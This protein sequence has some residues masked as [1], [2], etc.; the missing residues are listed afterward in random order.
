MGSIAFTFV[1]FGLS[2]YVISA[3][4][5]FSQ[6]SRTLDT[7]Q[8]GPADQSMKG[9]TFF[10]DNPMF[11][12]SFSYLNP[13]NRLPG[14]QSMIPHFIPHHMKIAH[15]LMNR[16]QQTD[17]NSRGIL[18]DIPELP[19]KEGIFVG[20]NPT[21][22]M[23]NDTSNIPVVSFRNAF[24]RN[25]ANQ[26]NQ[27]LG[28]GQPFFSQNNTA[29]TSSI[30]GL[31]SIQSD[32]SATNGEI[33]ASSNTIDINN[34][35]PSMQLVGSF[36]DNRG[37]P[38]M[39][40]VAEFVDISDAVAMMPIGQF[41]DQSNQDS[42]RNDVNS[43]PK[44]FAKSV[45]NKDAIDIFWSPSN[46]SRTANDVSDKPHRLD[47]IVFPTMRP[48]VSDA[49]L[50]PVDRPSINSGEVFS[51]T[52]DIL[53][54]NINEQLSSSKTNTGGIPVSPEVTGAI[55]FNLL[56]GQQVNEV[57]GATAINA[58]TTN[59]LKQTVSSNIISVPARSS[60]T[61]LIQDVNI[62]QI[63]SPKQPAPVIDDSRVGP[64]NM[65]NAMNADGSFSSVLK[66]V[67]IQK[68]SGGQG[69]EFGINAIP[70]VG[71]ETNK[72]L[73][74][75]IFNTDA[76][77]GKRNINGFGDSTLVTNGNRQTD[78]LNRINEDTN[79]RNGQFMT[80]NQPFSGRFE[81]NVPNDQQLNT[82]MI[83][84]SSLNGQN[85]QGNQ[86]RN[87]LTDR[88]QS[89]NKIAV[90]IDGTVIPSVQNNMQPVNDNF[91]SRIW[92][93]RVR[94]TTLNGNTDMPNGNGEQNMQ[95]NVNPLKSNM[96]AVIGNQQIA[97]NQDNGRV[98]TGV[99]DQ[100]SQSLGTNGQA[101]EENTRN[102]RLSMPNSPQPI[103]G[104]NMISGPNTFNNQFVGQTG[105]ITQPV[106]N[107]NMV[108]RVQ[109]GRPANIIG[110]S[111]PGEEG[112]H[113]GS[114]G[115]FP[116][117]NQVIVLN[118]QSTQ[119]IRTDTIGTVGENGQTF[120][121]NERQILGMT[122]SINNNIGTTSQ[123]DPAMT[124]NIRGVSG[125]SV[126]IGPARPL[127]GPNNA[128][129][130]WVSQS[131]MSNGITRALGQGNN[132]NQVPV[133][134]LNGNVVSNAQ[135]PQNVNNERQF[136]NMNKNGISTGSAQS[137]VPNGN[138][139]NNFLLANTGQSQLPQPM[140]N[141]QMMNTANVPMSPN[142]QNANPAI[143]SQGT[144]FNQPTNPQM[145]DNQMM[146][147]Q[148]MTNQ[149][150]NSIQ[151]INMQGM[152]LNQ[153][154]NNPGFNGMNSQV[155]GPQGNA[156]FNQMNNLGVNGMN[157]PGLN[158]MNNPGLNGM[159]SQVTGGMNSP[160]LNGMNS[161]PL[162]GM[163]SPSLNGMI[164]PQLNGMNSPQLNGM[165][166]P[167]LNGMNSHAGVQGNAMLN[168]MN[169]QGVNGMNSLN[170]NGMN[171]PGVNGMNNPSVNGM[172]NP[173]VNGI[174]PQVIGLQGNAMLNQMNS[175]S[176]N[177]V[178]SQGAN[179][180]NNPGTNE[181]NSK[182]TGPQGN[183]MFNQMNSRGVNGMNSPGVNVMNN[184]GENGMNSQVTGTQGNTMFNQINSRG[185]S[186]MNS[187]GV[188][189]MNSP[190][191]NGM[192]SQVTG[193]QGTAIFNQMN[194]QGIMQLPN[195]PGAQMNNMGM[196]QPS[197]GQGQ[198]S[199]Q[200]NNP[201][202]M[203]GNFQ[204]PMNGIPHSPNDPFTINSIGGFQGSNN[205]NLIPQQN[206]NNRIRN[207]DGSFGPP[208]QQ[209]N[210][211]NNMGQSMPMPFNG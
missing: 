150:M 136:Q 16:H 179:G 76:N 34:Q 28:N 27:V 151:P 173:V 26:D 146:N 123:D 93:I 190:G 46:R 42:K 152:N 96:G 104:N 80:E 157:S 35:N 121:L 47:D 197:N 208:M 86:F 187:P 161:P 156:I 60:Q 50:R 44:D 87:D 200:Q 175:P 99:F 149:K 113:G 141:G 131:G 120:N 162:N 112:P 199:G 29:A 103:S 115:I 62:Q 202:M 79:G 110:Q 132:Q 109:N 211:F 81:A 70:A 142:S 31:S 10:E 3:Q 71:D 90:G 15:I 198:V 100:G 102:G 183:A 105:L 188:N 92:D 184:P 135:L 49:N 18:G 130:P 177:G 61:Q 24:Q 209:Q 174:N 97:P 129:S 56:G 91:G 154:M 22:V 89:G 117:G 169:N 128:Q 8:D 68:M 185:I 12:D 180:M 106:M 38:L 6:P 160:Q 114:A 147:N 7:N 182:V 5:S 74:G 40:T 98:I 139:G 11:N 127:V 107:G 88:M 118:G 9:L 108:P 205:M 75:V 126:I 23:S 94:Q 69:K 32:S 193:S 57:G 155:T 19:A 63:S 164:S 167:G 48:P 111:I 172:N 196:I 153:Q 210:P 45:I 54:M 2:L 201:W 178:N 119:K 186:G 148:A 20:G 25:V 78:N 170:V 1:V 84:I 203:Q 52:N 194:S 77:S 189:G 176:V 72:R 82:G 158:V 43:S 13:S 207:F 37:K 59:N 140:I 122:Q 85:V 124:E 64:S 125:G 33:N 41:Q 116:Q 83:G 206:N 53:D 39:K 137:I 36:H 67:D 14:W 66:R 58:P 168:Q 191:V 134:L 17:T 138:I 30:F 144:R 51:R 145:T 73:E 195:G 171:N 204:N 165:N 192:N 181:M 143:Q 65:N 4:N 166:S 101:V 95:G 159:N 55:N 163:N 133:N 21:I